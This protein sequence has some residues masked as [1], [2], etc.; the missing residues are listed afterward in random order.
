MII[1]GIDPGTATMGYG[2][3]ERTGGSLRAVDYGALTTSA[4][5]PL[6]ERLAAIHACVVELIETHHPDLLAVERLFFSK[7]AQSAFG[8][9]QA[10]GV[11]L[12]AAAQSE[13]PVREAT[14]NEVK[15]GVTGYGNADKDQ[16]GRMV[17]VILQLTDV[18]TP[19]D[20]ADALAIAISTANAER[21]GD[22]LN[23]GT[24]GAKAGVLDRAAVA[25][26]ARGETPYER[27]VREALVT[28]ARAARAAAG[29]RGRG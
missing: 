18:P 10:R 27:A 19:D 3:V 21:A 1:L 13:V 28:E 4:D 16:V 25:P 11:V 20:T 6:P 7:N 9:G 24:A 12:L 17:A 15:V 22:R 14:P 5:L 26:I 29:A 23:G 2:I 8:V